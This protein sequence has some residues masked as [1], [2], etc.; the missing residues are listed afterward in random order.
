MFAF[1]FEDEDVSGTETI[2]NAVNPLDSPHLKDSLPPEWESLDSLIQSLNN[3]RLSFEKIS[4]FDGNI[5]FRRALFDIKHQLMVEDDGNQ[6]EILNSEDLR[7]NVYEGGLKSWECSIDLVDQLVKTN[8]DENCVLELGCGTALPSLY[9]FGQRLLHGNGNLKLILSDYNKSVIRLVTLPNLIITWSQLALTDDQ[10][11]QLQTSDQNVVA[12][13][14]L[15]T[16]Q[17][18]QA[19]QEDLSNRNIDIKFISGSWGRE[20]INMVQ[21]HVPPSLSLLNLTSETIYQPENLPVVAETLLQL[22]QRYHA[23]SLVAAKDIYFGVGGSVV[24]FESYLN[25][26]IK[27]QV[28]NIN[29][30]T[31]KVNAGL[32]RSIVY[33]H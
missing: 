23:R 25:K 30:N 12:D 8:I 1:G 14:L 15:L 17:L 13:E 19:F 29:F 11:H 16:P 28:L 24:E 10:R 27:S 31:L 7:K 26:C 20:F 6:L 32:K 5:L 33:V 9:V 18:L 22:H 21:Q 4:T 3:V 2:Q